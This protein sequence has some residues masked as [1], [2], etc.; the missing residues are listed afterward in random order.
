[1]MAGSLA[2]PGS[3]WSFCFGEMKAPYII[4]CLLFGVSIVAE[5]VAKQGYS[6]AAQTVAKAVTASPEIRKEAK[7]NADAFVRAGERV[8]MGGLI[9]ASVGAVL[10]AV[11]RLKGNTWTPVLPTVLAVA[12]AMMWLF[13]V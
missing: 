9:A 4:A 11:S 5:I 3:P 13:M 2:P 8:S 7:Q 12:Y 1:M 10:W 6:E